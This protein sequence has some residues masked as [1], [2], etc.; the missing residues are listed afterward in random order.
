MEKY[1]GIKFNVENL[2]K[3]APR[4]PK[5]QRLKYWCKIFDKYNF[6]PPYENGSCGNLS[7]RLKPKTDQ[8]IIT[9]SRIGLK[10]NLKPECFVKVCA[11]DLKKKKVYAMGIKEPSSESI[12]HWAIYNKRKDVGAIFH[13]HGPEILS[14]AKRL[15]IPTTKK[16]MP[17]GS[18]GLV[19][20]VLEIL[21][22]NNFL[23][24]KNHGFIALGKNMEEAGKLTMKIYKNCVVK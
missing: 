14:Q 24:M 22:N 11:C 3:E 5:I 21:K 9:G 6:A 18:V 10:S 1:R 2:K 12:M 23:I 17:Y 4:N 20:S 15:K 19:K 16:Q 13:G 7:F 8:F